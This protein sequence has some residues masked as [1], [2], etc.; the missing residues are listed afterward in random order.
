MVNIITNP[1]TY[2]G[3]QPVAGGSRQST[4]TPVAGGGQAVD[5]PAVQVSQPQPAYS[6][7]QASQLE[8]QR[9]Q[10]LKQAVTAVLPKFFYPVSDVRF[11]IFKDLS[12]QLVTKFTS[13]VTGETSQIPEPELLQF[14]GGSAP[15]V[16]TVV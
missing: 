9:V 3:Q 11:T 16:T 5:L 10:A 7:A 2:V 6:D 1:G 14:H 4:P 8:E 15:R 13:L 12:G